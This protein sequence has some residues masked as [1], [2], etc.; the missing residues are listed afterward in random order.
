MKGEGKEGN[1]AGWTVLFD[2]KS[3]AGWHP[4]RRHAKGK[5]WKVKEGAIH[6]DKSG[7][8]SEERADLV[9]DEL[10]SDFHL[11]LE[12]KISESGN[13]GVLFYVQDDPERYEQ[14]WMTGPEVQ[15][16]DNERHPD[17]DIPKRRASDLYDLIESAP[18][19]V[20]P[21]GAWNS[22]EI[23]SD[24]G[25]LEIYLNREKVILTKLWDDNW[26]QLNSTS[27]FKS[28]RGFGSYRSGRIALQDHGDEVWFRNIIIRKL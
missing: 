3:L 9:T 5:A 25:I 2:G 28:I 12:W 20:N 18:S 4:Y 26:Q 11:R 8:G 22:T 19:S 23:V 27:K 14:T 16:L 7:E 13:S 17:A 21:A 10:F 24:K 15:L 1:S 6:L